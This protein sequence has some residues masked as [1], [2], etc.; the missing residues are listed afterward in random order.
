MQLVLKMMYQYRNQTLN[1]LLLLLLVQL[2]SM[3][4]LLQ[5]FSLLFVFNNRSDQ[6]ETKTTLRP[7]PMASLSS[8]TNVST[9]QLLMPNRTASKS[10][11]PQRIKV[12]EILSKKIFY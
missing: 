4:Y 6:S 5:I 1:I 2:K 10:P 12:N 3:I 8:T 7:P 9:A 11:S